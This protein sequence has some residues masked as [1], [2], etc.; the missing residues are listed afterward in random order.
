MASQETDKG[1]N[2]EGEGTEELS[3]SCKS[4]DYKHKKEG[5]MKSHI[6]RQHVKKNKEKNSQGEGVPE[7]E[8]LEDEDDIE[9]D[10]ILMAEWNRPSVEEAT[11]ANK[12]SE[13]PP[14]NVEV[15]NAVTGQEGNLLRGGR[16]D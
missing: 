2:V 16:K 13:A 4:C 6:T 12:N 10:M 7:V 14:E 5:T 15:I 9:A 1:Y 3:F 11:V 8:V